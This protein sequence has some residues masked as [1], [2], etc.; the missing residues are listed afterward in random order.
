MANDRI[1]VPYNDRL[2]R[3]ETLLAGVKRAGDFFVHGSLDAPIPRV[4][5]DG[6]GVLSFPV[7]ASQIEASREALRTINGWIRG[8]L[9]PR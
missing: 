1:A 9:V 4:E 8:A 7:P 6:V 3:L 2:T 5:I